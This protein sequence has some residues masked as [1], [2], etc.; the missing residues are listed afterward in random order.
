LK[1]NDKK[2]NLDVQVNA[3]YSST[4]LG[5]LIKFLG[6]ENSAISSAKVLKNAVKVLVDNIL[7][8]SE[9]LNLEYLTKPESFRELH[10]K[11]TM[12]EQ[13]DVSRKIKLRSR[14]LSLEEIMKQS[15]DLDLEL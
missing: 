2:D 1:N 6:L 5:V 9:E 13:T 8:E 12:S 10:K 4:D 7:A 14:D 3:R 15:P 11:V